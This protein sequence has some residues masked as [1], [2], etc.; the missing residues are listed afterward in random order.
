MKIAW[1]VATLGLC[2]AC[3]LLD[4][5]PAASVPNVVSVVSPAEAMAE[6]CGPTCL[7]ERFHFTLA[8]QGA[9]NA[10]ASS[11]STPRPPA[12]W[13]LDL[14]DIPKL[15]KKV[16]SWGVDPE[17]L[18]DVGYELL[19]INSAR[20]FGSFGTKD[21]YTD[22][23]FRRAARLAKR[24]RV[25]LTLNTSPWHRA[26]GCSADPLSWGPDTG[27]EMKYLRD[28]LKRTKRLGLKVDAILLD[29]ECYKQPH[30]LVTT[31]L[32]MAYDVVRAEYPTTPIYWYRNG[33]WA[34]NFN[35]KNRNHARGDG[36]ELVSRTFVAYRVHDPNYNELWFNK[37]HAEF[38]DAN[39]WGK[40][41]TLGAGYQGGWQ[42]DLELD[43]LY[44]YE[45]GRRFASDERISVGLLYP[46]FYRIKS[47]G[48]HAAAAAFGQ[49]AAG[50]Q[51]RPI[52]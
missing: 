24:A 14:V 21:T 10:L 6:N 30:T 43:P 28:F 22:D 35:A 11:P 5:K 13:I 12:G 42:W 2:V 39:D 36:A 34:P 31:R 17:V 40:W 16:Y 47:T 33:D 50:L 48:Y 20:I 29:S 41:F 1:S 23:Q 45:E 26:G 46:G 27:A 4:S 25:G 44:W 38:P 7:D 19:L 8:Y 52:S 49:G 32:D 18:T 3:S 15:K 51:F 37:W 9:R